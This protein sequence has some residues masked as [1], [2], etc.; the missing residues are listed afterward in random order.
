MHAMP[1][2]ARSRTRHPQHAL[3]SCLQA[4]LQ[5][6]LL[7]NL[8]SYHAASPLPLPPPAVAYGVIEGLGFYITIHSS[9]SPTQVSQTASS[10]SSPVLQWRTG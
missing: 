9:F 1:C 7:H 10:S 6:F 3:V 8:A 4:G 2:I 5:M